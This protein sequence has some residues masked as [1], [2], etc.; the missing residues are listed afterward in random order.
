MDQHYVMYE[1]V[2]RVH[3]DLQRTRD[4][5][6]KFLFDFTDVGPIFLRPRHDAEGALARQSGIEVDVDV[7]DAVPARVGGILVPADRRAIAGVLE[8]HRFV[9]RDQVPA[10]QGL[11]YPQ[12]LRAAEKLEGSRP[13][14]TVEIVHPEHDLAPVASAKR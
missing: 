5:P 13:P 4:L 2:A 9:R 14:F 7:E 8:H 12:N 10:G 6:A 3:L 11:R 1:D